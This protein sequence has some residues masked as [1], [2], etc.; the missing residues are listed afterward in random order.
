MSIQLRSRPV[1]ARRVT[2]IPNHNPGL[3]VLSVSI[4]DMGTAHWT[5]LPVLAFQAEQTDPPEFLVADW[6][7]TI[8]DLTGE[9]WCLW[10]RDS[11]LC[12]SPADSDWGFALPV[13]QAK[14]ELLEEAQRL[15]QATHH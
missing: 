6:P 3:V 11:D 10:D 2:L 1:P 12:Y 9:A 14:T 13:A 7:V 15:A 8:S 4:D 5:T